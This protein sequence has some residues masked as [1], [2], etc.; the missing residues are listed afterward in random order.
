MSEH[1]NTIEPE[2]RQAACY[3]ADFAIVPNII[4]RA[5]GGLLLSPGGVVLATLI[6]GRPDRHNAP[7]WAFEPLEAGGLSARLAVSR[8]AI[9]RYAGELIN[10]GVLERQGK[11]YRLAEWYRRKRT[12]Q[13]KSFTRVPLAPLADPSMSIAAKAAYIALQSFANRHTGLTWIAVS[14]LAAAL[15]RT[16]RPT[17]AVLRSLERAGH[18]ES[19]FRRKNTTVYRLQLPQTANTAPLGLKYSALPRE[20]RDSSICKA[21]ARGAKALLSATAAVYSLSHRPG[22]EQESRKS[23]ARAGTREEYQE[24]VTIL[25][26]ARLKMG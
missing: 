5:Q 1:P 11:R 3:R 10:A 8:A 18:L 13:S 14:T 20:E 23:W 26:Q 12:V 22:L 21:R 17:Q 16:R 25:E 15:G 4:T 6:C 2:T 19:R 7:G 9:W 24:A